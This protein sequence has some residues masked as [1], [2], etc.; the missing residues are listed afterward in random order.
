MKQL[1]D[2][3]NWARKEHFHFFR[4]FE[5]PFFGVCADVDCTGAY[6]RAQGGQGSFFLT[7]L[8]ATLKAAN[9]IEPF[10]YRINDGQV[11]VYDVVHASPT[12]NRPDGSFGFAYIDYHEDFGLF[13]EAGNREIHRVRGSKGLAPAV[14][15]ENVLHCSAL[16]WLSFTGLSHARAFSFADSCP[17]ISF[18]KIK[19]QQGRKMMP[20]SVHVHHA[21]MDGY[22]VGLFYERLTALLTN[23]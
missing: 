21:L 12:I 11:W 2:I 4:Q 18:G 13:E 5:E 1:L 16:P 20:V 10:R 14:S 7:Y 15:G 19:D 22:H 9:A 3:D 23:P 17:K 6:Q 8:H